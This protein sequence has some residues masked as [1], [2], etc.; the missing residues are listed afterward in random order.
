MN[1]SNNYISLLFQYDVSL[2][3][4]ILT[5]DF[6]WQAVDVLPRMIRLKSYYAILPHYLIY[7]GPND[8]GLIDREWETKVLIAIVT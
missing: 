2:R 4:L 7:L 5:N 6:F 8:C 1:L 3:F